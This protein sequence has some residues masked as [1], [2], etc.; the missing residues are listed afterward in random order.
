MKYGCCTFFVATGEDRIG[1]ERV[2]Q[3]LRAGYDFV[4]LPMAELTGLPEKT[5]LDY[6]D[7][8][9]DLGI[10]CSCAQ[11]FV[12]RNMHFVGEDATEIP[13]FEDYCR[14]AFDRANMLGI[15]H[16]VF[17]SFWTKNVPEG[18]SFQR[19]YDQ[20]VEVHTHIDRWARDA[21]VIIGIEPLRRPMCNIINT[22]AEGCRLAEDVGGTNLKV[23]LDNYHLDAEKEPADVIGTRMHN[24]GHVHFS[25][26]NLS[27]P[28]RYFP[29]S[30]EEWDYAPMAEALKKYGYDGTVTIEAAARNFDT[31]VKDAL[32]FT[33][34]LFG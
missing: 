22:F 23:V 11:N 7:R 27:G 18:F 29:L 17:G 1:M 6:R 5:F 25:N 8:L 9:R 30:R 31:D 24:L 15:G 21:G 4:E 28:D 3:I 13:V 20:L 26:P 19:A 14:R 34:S 12:P 2:E 32:E 16:I 33:R 10:P